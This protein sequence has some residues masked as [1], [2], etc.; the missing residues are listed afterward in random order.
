MVPLSHCRGDAPSYPSRGIPETSSTR[1][2]MQQ[3]MA[4][5]GQHNVEGPQADT[6]DHADEKGRLVASTLL[7]NMNQTRSCDP[8]EELQKVQIFSMSEE[9][10]HKVGDTDAAHVSKLFATRVAVEADPEVAANVDGLSVW[11]AI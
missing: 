5:A 6:R 8:G 3:L 10:T 11:Y 2:S 7:E 9:S 1:K 4:G